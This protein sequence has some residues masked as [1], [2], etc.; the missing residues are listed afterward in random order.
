M[1]EQDK[2]PVATEADTQAKPASEA[3]SARTQGDD[4][5]TFLSQFDSATKPAP[6][7]NPPAKAETTQPENVSIDEIRAMRAEFQQ[8][9][10]DRFKREISETVK[11]IRG[12]VD[13]EV[14]DDEMVEAWLDAKA[15]KDPRLAQAFANKANKPREWSQIKSALGREFKKKWD[16]IPDRA[17]TEDR[18]A[19]AAAVRGASTK[20][21]PEPPANLGGMSTAEYRQH[22]R[23]QYG[24]DPGV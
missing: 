19:V 9:A 1:S 13:P 16:K 6:Q 23:Q 22:V 18:E 12:D 3:D 24:F 7:P 14:V 4:I 10:Q 20:A 8:V 11:D 5:E 17:V 2:Q 15:R 21:S